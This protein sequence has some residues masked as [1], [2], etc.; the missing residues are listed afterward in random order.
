MRGDMADPREVCPGCEPE[1]EPI[2]Y[3]TAYCFSHRPDAAGLDDAGVRFSETFDTSGT[4]ETDPKTNRAW[5][6]LFHRGG[7][8]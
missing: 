7:T 4:A 2:H 5:C 1:E 6:T 8:S 3:V